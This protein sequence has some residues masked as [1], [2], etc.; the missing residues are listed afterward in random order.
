[1]S[2]PPLW[3]L[4]RGNPDRPAVVFLHG[5]LGDGTDW[6]PVA[7]LV[8][9]DVH[10]VL[11]D[12]PGHGR[13]AA[14]DPAAPVAAFARD[15]SVALSQTVRGPYVLC[16]YSMGARLGLAALV[17]GLRPPA[18]IVLES[19]NPGI[20]D[21]AARAERRERDL[22]L[23]ARL[24]SN[25]VAF[26]REWYEQPLF[27]SL[28]KK[29]ALLSRLRMERTNLNA[30]AVSAALAAFSPGVMPDAWPVLRNLACPVLALAG[31]LDT[32]YAETAPKIAAA[33]SQGAA[34]LLPG[35]GHNL[36]RE[37]PEAF[38]EALL[39]FVHSI[40]RTPA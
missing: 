24:R 29:P 21:P 1:M 22:A 25:P 17:E 26:L 4:S 36:H 8:E 39:E 28:T 11:V 37:D 2:T 12:L 15:L 40:E 19:G 31:E 13:S 6:A 34:R 9:D 18:G 23:A 30:P 33:A 32:A 3:I 20:V 27:A 38:A 14:P 7:D 35:V 5:F 16:G 10:C